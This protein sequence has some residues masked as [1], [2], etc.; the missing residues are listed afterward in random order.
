MTDPI[1]NFQVEM[2]Q[3]EEQCTIPGEE[4]PLVLISLVDG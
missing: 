2:K 4:Y 3:P 1:S